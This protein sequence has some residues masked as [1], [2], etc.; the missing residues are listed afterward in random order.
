MNSL[1]KI[2]I[3]SFAHH[4]A[5]AYINTVRNV[6]GVELL[7]LAD[8]DLQRGQHFARTFQAPYFDSYEALLNAR[9][10][11]VL[12]CSENS[13]HRPLVEMAA[14]AARCMCCARNRW[15][16]SRPIRKRWSGL[17]R[18]VWVDDGIPMRFSTPLLEVKAASMRAIWARSVLQRDESG[19]SAAAPAPLVRG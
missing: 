17:P 7:W 10:D 8:E 13:K 5:E 2:G 12:V 4:H 15:R 6:P 1:V 9:P 11:A 19:R 16:R 3:M 14:A 18:L